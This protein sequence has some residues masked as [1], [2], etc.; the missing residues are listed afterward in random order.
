MKA[1]TI[2]LPDVVHQR[3]KVEA[4]ILKTSIADIARL[5]LENAPGAAPAINPEALKILAAEVA[6]LRADSSAV[7]GAL[8]QVESILHDL[9]LAVQKLYQPSPNPPRQPNLP[10]S[11]TPTFT[12]PNFAAWA[13]NLPWLEGEEKAQRVHRLAQV[14]RQEFGSW[15]ANYTP[16]KN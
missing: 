8:K 4:E 3:L 2:R 9:T 13:A 7:Q 11:N 5:R 1:L 14:Y 6:E 12:P 16:P 10:G 15:P